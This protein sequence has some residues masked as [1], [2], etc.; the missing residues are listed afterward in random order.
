LFTFQNGGELEIKNILLTYQAEVYVRDWYKN[1]RIGIFNNRI[2]A[3]CTDYTTYDSVDTTQSREMIIS[4][5]YDLTNTSFVISTDKA[6]N[7]VIGETTHELSDND[8]VTVT[9]SDWILPVELEKVVEDNVKLTTVLN[10]SDN[11]VLET[12]KYLVRFDQDETLEPY[13]TT[14]DST[15]YDE[16]TDE[17]IFNNA[18]YWGTAPQSINT[19]ENISTEF[20][21][22]ENY[23]LILLITGDYPE[24]TIKETITYTEPRITE[25]DNINDTTRTYPEPIHNT[26]TETPV[27]L[28]LQAYETSTPIQLYNLPLPENTG[29]TENN[30]IKGIE[31]TG[32]INQSSSIILNATLHTPNGEKGQRSIRINTFDNDTDEETNKFTL[33]GPTDLWGFSTLDLVNLE[34]WQIELQYQNILTDSETSINF[35]NIQLII[36]FEN[37]EHNGVT[38]TIDGENLA[39]YGAFINNIKIPAG[40]S[41][42]VDYLTIDGTDTNDPYRQ[43]IREKT[44]EIEF[45]LGD[46]NSL[47]NNTTQLNQLL[48]LLINEKDKYNRPIPKRIEFEHLPD[49]YYEYII[50]D[51]IDTD[52]DIDTYTIKAKLVIPAGTSYS[53]QNTVT[54]T[55]GYV[56]GLANINPVIIIKPNGTD[57]EIQE[58]FTGQ[59]LRITLPEPYNNQII[60][61][62]CEDRTTYL[63]TNE[64]DTNPVNITQYVDFNSDW[65]SLKGE[66]QF[67]STNCILQTI[68]YNERW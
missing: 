25:N 63:K 54:N 32:D 2:E 7:I 46:C 1:F 18:S 12:T 21:Y 47:T 59:K 52:I 34:Q 20:Q 3:N 44:I 28:T 66:Y 61:I 48:Q 60:E 27:E 10:G 16:L 38:V 67:T 8:S 45:E 35:A 37:I 11:S 30:I 36:Y 24:A 53:K 51:T 31:I 4:S 13:T 64:D 55:T 58:T 14:E 62:D 42:D 26:V 68:D 56:K 17:D 29:T 5:R 65:F 41:T 19:Y 6:V 23:P 49:V 15:D 9:L 57:I 33:G 50:T 22:N 39:Y 40:L 43:N